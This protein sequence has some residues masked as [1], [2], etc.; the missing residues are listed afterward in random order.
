M[1]KVLLDHLAAMGARDAEAQT[2]ASGML[3]SGAIYA[4]EGVED[5]LQHGFGNTR[6]PI[7][8]IDH[9]LAIT[10]IE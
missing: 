3:R 10:P 5:P 4:N 1:A 8:D 9:H 6:P 2:I 7:V